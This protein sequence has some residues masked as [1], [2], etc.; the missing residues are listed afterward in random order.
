MIKD[1]LLHSVI[2]TLAV[3]PRLPTSDGERRA[4]DWLHEQ[5]ETYGCRT[6]VEQVPA[7]PSYAV[8]IGLMSAAAAAGAWAGGRGHRVLGAVVAGLAAAGIV[9]DIDGGHNVFRRLFLRART[10]YNVVAVTGDP[11]ATRTLVVLAHHDAAPS[12]VVFDTT[13]NDWLAK[14]R[15]DLIEAMTSNPPLWWPVIAGPVLAGLG[16]ASGSAGLR[17]AGLALSLASAAAMA[18]IASRGPVPGANDNL[19]GV[20]ALVGVARALHDEPVRGLRVMLVSAGAEEAIQ[21]GIR[22]FADLH[23]DTLP[24]ESTTFLNLDTVGSGR[25]VLLAGEGP[26]RM[27][28]YDRE[29]ADLVARCAETVDVPLLRGLRS[30]NSTD[31]SVPLRHGYPTATLV[32]VDDRKLLPHYHLDTDLPENVDMDCVAGAAR[33]VEAVARTLASREIRS[34]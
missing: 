4:A 12:G 1:D 23:F 34:T 17:R 30:R 5:F 18:D 26:V 19:S 13:V 32:S 2:D 21:Q 10:A 20:A 8:P 28:D 25:L 9:D 15:P 14:R 31:G 7:Y 22:G 6:A 33:L 11:T 29:T 27:H 24:R 16:S 3:V